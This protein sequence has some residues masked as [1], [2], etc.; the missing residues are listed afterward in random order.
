VVGC[1]GRSWYDGMAW[2][3]GRRVAL[4]PAMDSGTQ[5]VVSGCISERCHDRVYL[6]AVLGVHISSCV[7]A[8]RV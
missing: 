6:L 7:C 3:A 4:D 2:S 1:C 5:L 8:A